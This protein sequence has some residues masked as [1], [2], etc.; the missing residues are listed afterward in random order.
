[1]FH[2][3]TI[4]VMVA[5]IIC[6]KHMKEKRPLF[7]KQ[8]IKTFIIVNLIRCL[9]YVNVIFYTCAPCSELPSGLRTLISSMYYHIDVNPF[10]KF[11]CNKM[12]RKNLHIQIKRKKNYGLHSVTQS[13]VCQH[14]FCHFSKK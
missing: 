7:S 9:Y 13:R 4:V 12:A 8:K 10:A 6:C 5:Q 1:M 14:Y 11:Q 2:G 3:I